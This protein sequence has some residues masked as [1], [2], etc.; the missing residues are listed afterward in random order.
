MGIS[1]AHSKEK[2]WRIANEFPKPNYKV[3]FSS[4]WFGNRFGY[5]FEY[6]FSTVWLWIS[7][8]SAISLKVSQIIQKVQEFLKKGKVNCKTVTKWIQNT[9]DEKK[10]ESPNPSK[11]QKCIQNSIPEK[12]L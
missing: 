7:F 10:T 3:F 9:I 4:N 12:F 6:V 11:T 5:F 2:I 8:A 1:R